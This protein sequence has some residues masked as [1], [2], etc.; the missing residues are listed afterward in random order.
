MTIYY[1]EGGLRALHA[2]AVAAEERQETMSPTAREA[3]PKA[4]MKLVRMFPLVHIRDDEHLEAA[5]EMLTYVLALG[6]DDQG[7]VDYLDVLTDLVEAYEKEHVHIPDA[8]EAEVLG[9]L[10]ESRTLSQTRLAEETG[11]AQATISNVLRG[12]R[13]LTKDQVVRLAEFFHVGPG[14]FLPAAPK[15]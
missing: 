6:E 7:V 9:F 15:K 8:S 11:I 3:P 2:A 13:G 12:P 1:V 4:Y 14:A 10:M 5:S